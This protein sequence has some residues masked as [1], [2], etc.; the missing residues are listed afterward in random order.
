[1]EDL[2]VGTVRTLVTGHLGYIGT[3]LVPML[4]RRGHEVVGLDSDLYRTCT[5]G[6]ADGI[7]TVETILKDIRDI[8]IAD[9]R[10]FDAVL[11]LAGLSNDPLG[12][13]DPDLTYEINH[14][15][16]VRLAELAKRAGVGRFVFSSSCSNYG[17]AG[18][19]LL[20]EEAAFH[21]VT[22]YGQS[23]VLVEQDVARLADDSF[24]PVFLRNATAYGYSP[25]LRFD[26]VVNNLTAW[27]HTTGKIHLKSDGSAWRPLVHVE[28]ISR[29][30]IAAAEAPREK[31]HNEAFNVCATDENYLV[32]DV[33]TIVGKV[34]PDSEVEF[35]SGASADARNYRVNGDK[36][37]A[38]FKSFRPQWTVRKGVEELYAKYKEIGV[39]LDEFEGSRY[40]RVAHIQSLM[41]RGEIDVRL[42]VQSR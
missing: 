12:D 41:S 39:T 30:F 22:P 25:R 15:A 28:D 42:R 37:A 6:P 2:G 11:H 9:V 27:A 31:V 23:K 36:F 26:L 10:G 1:V 14:Q 7:T 19:D 3:V 21:P 20:G 32:R 29:A 34:V 35:A 24:S 5:F 17:A 18:D 40:K 4:L 8:E 38:A 33:A 16:S 13:L